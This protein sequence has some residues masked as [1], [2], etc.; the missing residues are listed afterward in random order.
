MGKTSAG[1]KSLGSKNRVKHAVAPKSSPVKEPQT[2]LDVIEG[3][4]KKFTQKLVATSDASVIAVKVAKTLRDC[5]KDWGKEL[6]DELLVGDLTLRQR[7]IND[8]THPKPGQQFGK[9]YNDSLKLMYQAQDDPSKK[10]VVTDPTQ[11]LPATLEKAM[12][13]LLQHTP[14]YSSMVDLMASQGQLNQRS[15][16]FL[17][18]GILKVSP[19]RGPQAR[20]CIIAVLKWFHRTRSYMSHPHEFK[21]AVD[22]FDSAIARTLEACRS[23]GQTGQT[24]WKSVKQIAPLVLPVG[25]FEKLLALGKDD[26]FDGHGAE[27]EAVTAT[28]VG[29]VMFEAV[30]DQRKQRMMKAWIDGEITRLSHANFTQMLWNESL[31]S[32]TD[33]CEAN[34][35]VASDAHDERPFFFK[36]R[37][38]VTSHTVTSYSQAYAVAMQGLM[39]TFGVESGKV[40]SLFCEDQL[41]S[42]GRL[43]K[44]G[45]TIDQELVDGIVI[46]RAAATD[47]VQ[48]AMI[49]EQNMAIAIQNVLIARNTTLTELHAGWKVEKAFFLGMMGESGDLR[50]QALICACLPS[51]RDVVT[52]DAALT[53]LRELANSKLHRFVSI[54]SQVKL[55]NVI[56]YVEAIKRTRPPHFTES[57][58]VTWQKKIKEH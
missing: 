41:V 37:T 32:F 53:S 10:L 34:D 19:Y 14:L 43:T 52:Y 27:L 1:A 54:T 40:K 44:N 36:Y 16:V 20:S 13:K 29:A 51:A 15:V 8:R 18:R 4:G 56:G 45:T 23:S 3:G 33:F 26:S 6:M 47:M 22:H 48:E 49:T 17:L 38:T 50:Y 57:G 39:A 35:I 2:L 7:M 46:A 25:P 31:K 42:V 5:F 58:D 55:S 9:N 30:A 12:M 11:E 28:A 24:L 21:H